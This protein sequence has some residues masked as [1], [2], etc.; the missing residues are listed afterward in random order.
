[1]KNITDTIQG[2]GRKT[3]SFLLASIIVVAAGAAT[4]DTYYLKS[5]PTAS[6]TSDPWRAENLWTNAL[7]AAY[8]ITAEG[9]GT[10]PNDFVVPLG[11]TFLGRHG[12]TS[13]T[14][15]FPGKT[16][17]ILANG[18]SSGLLNQRTVV[19]T[20]PKLVLDASQ[21]TT[22]M[23]MIDSNGIGVSIGAEDSSRMITIAG[24][25]FEVK[26][27]D[28][29]YAIYD[30]HGGTWTRK[31]CIA[32][33]LTG[34][35]N[36]MFRTRYED[37]STT[38]KEVYLTGDNSGFTGNLCMCGYTTGKDSSSPY[39]WFVASDANQ[40]GG[41]PETLRQRGFEIRR[42]SNVRFTQSMVIDQP[43]RGLYISQINGDNSSYLSRFE[44]LDGCNVVYT[45]PWSFSGNTCIFQKYGKGLLNLTGGIYPGGANGWF[46]I[47]EGVLKLNAQD[48][49][50]NANLTAKIQFYGSNTTLQL[51]SNGVAR[52]NPTYFEYYNNA[53][54][55]AIVDAATLEVTSTYKPNAV[56]NITIASQATLSMTGTAAVA[57]N[58]VTLEDGATLAYHFSSTN[59]TS[60]PALS[61]NSGKV[62]SLPE[63]GSVKVR[64][65]AN[66]G[67][68]FNSVGNS[69]TGYELTTG[70]SLPVDAVTSG[71]IQF[72]EG[73]PSWARRLAI[74][75]GN[76][77]L[78]PY[79]PG[80]M[81]SVR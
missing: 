50:T 68:Y 35:G 42:V 6:T 23:V 16:M 15:E 69:E 72:A 4:A 2:G 18:S 17:T 31:F 56:T 7:G 10:D 27:K 39:L 41:N 25:E 55:L 11:R 66:E 77:K 61:I 71:K 51:G 22:D 75:D 37:G 70:Y 54:N 74:E 62:L 48:I 38:Y 49:A 3:Y 57:L 36:M 28:N 64:I 47:Y 5:T 24:D 33:P 67:L 29:L 58:N 79:G 46:K 81:L 73:K 52:V 1:M 8:T 40:L 20:F 59:T 9:A 45:G 65:T 19:M 32:S 53:G 34:T 80:L 26:T 44:V 63:T 76:L 12:S 14:A 60:V 78:Y 43:N 13:Y 21:A 30:F